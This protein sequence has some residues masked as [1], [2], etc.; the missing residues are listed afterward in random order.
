M[1]EYVMAKKVQLTDVVLQ[2]L[3]EKVEFFLDSTLEPTIRVPDDG[4]QQE[5]PA[6]SQRVHDLLNAI[7]YDATKGTILKSAQREFLLSQIREECRKGG[8]RLSDIEVEQTDNDVI[9]QGLLHFMNTHDEFNDLTAVL[10][11]LLRKA[12]IEGKFSQ[13]EEIPVFTNIFSRRLRRLIP[14]LR[15]YGIEVSIEHKESGSHCKVVRLESFSVEPDASLLAPV[16][17][18][19]SQHKSSGE[20]SGASPRKGRD[21]QTADGADGETRIDS[22][23]DKSGT[24]S[25]TKSLKDAEGGDQ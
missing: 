13:R 14:V 7:Y 5:W 9:V 16:E 3:D 19:D 6:D 15:G 10:L 8:R 2:L 18:D 12:Q 20:S 23:A 22:P 1:S 21:L 17:T 4:F 24:Q 25:V 11:G